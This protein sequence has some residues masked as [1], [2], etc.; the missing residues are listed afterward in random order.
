MI[1]FSPYQRGVSAGPGTSIWIL[2][3]LFKI[4]VPSLLLFKPCPSFV[5]LL[6]W[7]TAGTHGI[8]L[9][10]SCTSGLC[11]CSPITLR[12]SCP[13]AF[14]VCGL[15]T[16][17]ID[18]AGVSYSASTV[19]L[20]LVWHLSAKKAWFA[21]KHLSL[22]QPA[23]C[24]ASQLSCQGE[25]ND[26]YHFCY[27]AS[28]CVRQFLLKMCSFTLTDVLPIPLNACGM[29]WSSPR[30]SLSASASAKKLLSSLAD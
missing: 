4:S 26:P 15:V 2:A 13:A 24:S 5:L 14:A 8:V 9:A 27:T 29:L 11:L 21:Y 1:A 7:S 18:T 10:A 23:V 20:L 19:K 28:V 22:L 16:C 30:P 25:K 17:W 6:G 3:Q 12:S